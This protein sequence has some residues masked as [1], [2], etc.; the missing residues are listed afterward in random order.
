MVYAMLT[1]IYWKI[2]SN[3]GCWGFSVV[4]SQLGFL[5]LIGN[6]EIICLSC[7]LFLDYYKCGP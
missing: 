4:G 3:K 2:V 5:S 6:W 7:Y 1:Y